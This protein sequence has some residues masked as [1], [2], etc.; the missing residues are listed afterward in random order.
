MEGPVFD[1]LGDGIAA[2]VN[3]VPVLFAD[4][5]SPNDGLIRTMLGLL[6]IMFVVYLLA[7][8]PLRPFY[9]RWIERLSRLMGRHP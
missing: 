9:A 3:D 4:K 2:I 8:R 7:M 5:S 6:L 1:W